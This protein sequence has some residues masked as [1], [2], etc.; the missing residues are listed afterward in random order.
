M[1]KID[2]GAD[3]SVISEA[4]YKS[5]FDIPLQSTDKFLFGPDSIRLRI[6]S[7]FR[8]RLRLKD[9]CAN[10]E[11]CVLRDLHQPMLG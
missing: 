7:K 2:S 3:V 9:A 11:I 4:V 8:T 1:F 5:T 6:I 10:V